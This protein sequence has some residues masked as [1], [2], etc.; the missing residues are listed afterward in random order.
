M[1]YTRLLVP[2]AQ[3]PFQVMQRRYQLLGAA[4]RRVDLIDECI[5]VRRG[6][7]VGHQVSA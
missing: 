1:L 5:S 6:V 2:D 4:F 7:V 3:H